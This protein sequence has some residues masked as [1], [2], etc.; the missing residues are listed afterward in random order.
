MQPVA[1]VKVI[2][3]VVIT[4]VRRLRKDSSL[5]YFLAGLEATPH[6]IHL[7]EMKTGVNSEGARRRGSESRV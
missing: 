5:K 2:S 4:K 1:C 7:N 3:Y 6:R